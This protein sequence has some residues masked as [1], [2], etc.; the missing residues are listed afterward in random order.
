MRLKN[1]RFQLFEL[2]SYFEQKSHR[3]ID[4]LFQ[5]FVS[6][7]D[8]K[9]VILAL[10]KDVAEKGTLKEETSKLIVHKKNLKNVPV[11][12]NMTGEILIDGPEK[13]FEFF[14]NKPITYKDI[15]AIAF[16]SRENFEYFKNQT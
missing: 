10:N 14:V 6:F 1:Q 16:N 13:K 7:K 15:A 8:D 4:F 5:Q 2:I 3:N 11:N 12:A 9:G